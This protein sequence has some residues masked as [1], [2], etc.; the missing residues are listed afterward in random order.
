[1]SLLNS[2][3]PSKSACITREEELS[4]T[5]IQFTWRELA[6]LGGV[7]LAAT[8]AIAFVQT[9]I[10]LPGHAILKA[11]FP[12]ACGMA[13]V[14]KPLAGT[15]ACSA[16]LFT[17]A[18]LLLAGFGNLQTAALVSLLLVGPAFD[19]ARSKNNLNRIAKLSRFA[20]VGCAVNLI[21]FVVRWGTSFWQADGW[22]LLNFRAL[23]SAAIVSFAVCGIGAGIV[24]GILC[25]ERKPR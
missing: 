19:W 24:C 17:A 13:F 11:V 10:R 12:L 16:S 15:V 1:M 22:H 18:L 20:L 21:A 6:I 8:V 4:D 3:L 23:G 7:G 14:A 25:R 9:P 5:A 2:H